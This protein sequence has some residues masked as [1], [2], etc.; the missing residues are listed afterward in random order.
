MYSTADII[1][2][3]WS[4]CDLTAAPFHLKMC[5]KGHFPFCTLP[6]HMLLASDVLHNCGETAAKTQLSPQM[7]PVLVSFRAKL[8]VW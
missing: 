7:H 6:L 3:D 4:K 5:S 8:A 1:K 2:N